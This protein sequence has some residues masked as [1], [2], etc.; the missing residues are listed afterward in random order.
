MKNVLKIRFL[1]GLIMVVFFLNASAFAEGRDEVFEPKLLIAEE[2]ITGLNRNLEYSINNGKSWK[3]VWSSELPITNIIPKKTTV[4]IRIRTK[5]YGGVLREYVELDI[6]ARASA[7]SGLV[8]KG[9]LNKITGVNENHEYRTAVSKW[10]NVEND[11]IYTPEQTKQTIFFIRSKATAENFSSVEAK[12]TIKAPAAAPKAVYNVAKDNITGVSSK[13]E[14]FLIKGDEPST[15][16]TAISVETGTETTTEDTTEDITEDTTED[17]TEDKTEDTTVQYEEWIRIPTGKTSLT[18]EQFGKNGATIKIRIAA[19]EKTP[20]SLIKV[21]NLPPL[22]IN[23]FTLVEL[24]Y[25]KEVLTCMNSNMQYSINKGKTW[26]NITATNLKDSVKMADSVTSGSFSLT[27]F[28]PKST[29]TADGTIQIR[30]KATKTVPPSTIKQIDIRKRPA[31]P[32]KTVVYFDPQN[33]V[34][35][36]NE[37]MGYRL[38][39][40]GS[41]TKVEEGKTEVE[42]VVSTKA[43]TYQVRIEPKGEVFASLPLDVAVAARPIAPNVSYAPVKDNLTG[44]TNKMEYM[45][46]IETESTTEISTEAT[47][48][49]RTETTTEGAGFE[50]NA[51]SVASGQW[52]KVGTGVTTITVPRKEMGNVKLIAYARVASTATVPASLPKT[53]SIPAVPNAPNISINYVK[54]TFTG[55]ESTM[56]FSKDASTWT[57]I[58]YSDITEH[59]ISIEKLVS[60][61]KSTDSAASI[62]VYIRHNAVTT[63]IIAPPS[64]S[65]ELTLPRRTAAPTVDEVKF[66]TSNETISVKEG[67]S[68]RKGT[69]GDYTLVASG[70]TTITPEISN[71]DEILYQ[72]RYD[73]A[74]SNIFASEPILITIPARFSKPSNVAFDMATDTIKNVDSTMEFAKVNANGEVE[75][76]WTKVGSGEIAIKRSSMVSSAASY[77]VRISATSAK[78]A[79]NTVKVDV[80][81]KTASPTGLGINYSAEL[82]LGS[83]VAMEYSQNNGAIWFSVTQNEMDLSTLVPSTADLKLLVRI[84]A[85]SATPPSDAVEVVVNKRPAA[86]SVSYNGAT[87]SINATEEMEYR[88]GLEKTFTNVNSGSGITDVSPNSGYDIRYS[89]TGSN[90]ASNITRIVVP[91]ASA[92]P[93]GIVYDG[94]SM[95]IKNVISTMEYKEESSGTWTAVSGTTISRSNFG[96]SAV[97]VSIRYKGTQTNPPSKEVKINLPQV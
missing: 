6:P 15:S 96:S 54:E 81:D 13:M 97:A 12:V 25:E 60:I 17:K 8:Y 36:V 89:A 83:T 37:A 86:P 84:K 78:P 68:Y 80:P 67:M 88:T 34:I 38:G 22:N 10:M 82:L 26:V 59:G 16:T 46:V 23:N 79:S 85:T 72:V 2:K 9:T 41:Y 24:N 91:S 66:N 14:Y 51:D 39:K 31:T 43:V 21:I 55:V 3:D 63:G 90:F 19:T 93:T 20:A 62:K 71:T 11:G 69:T 94:D 65:T 42:K 18:R 29:A 5:A 53:L 50:I 87:E 52:V 75:T 47:T 61:P 45:F 92:A 4:K 77:F 35:K 57:N 48:E 28:V 70:Q 40:T 58:D 30:I 74:G 76:G 95:E 1:M 32:T 7:P 64:L 73:A 27:S 44:L 56:Q 33:E 49:A